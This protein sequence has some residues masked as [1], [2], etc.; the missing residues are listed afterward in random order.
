M[1]EIHNFTNKII[2]IIIQ[3]KNLG[4]K[5]ILE[6]DNQRGFLFI[7]FALLLFFC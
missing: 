4:A 7:L 3:E 5:G 1:S 6:N 2:I